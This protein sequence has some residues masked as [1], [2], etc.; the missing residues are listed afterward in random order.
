M[1]SRFTLSVAMSCYTGARASSATKEPRAIHSTT[2]PGGL[3]YLTPS[4]NFWQKMKYSSTNLSKLSSPNV[5][6]TL[7]FSSVKRG[8]E[9]QDVQ[10]PLKKSSETKTQAQ[11]AVG[12]CRRLGNKSPKV[13]VYQFSSL[14]SFLHSIQTRNMPSRIQRRETPPYLRLES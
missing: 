13:K 1:I 4:L 6:F 3:G 12:R 8:K 10:H 7:D 11:Q 9:A 14:P 5:T 2:S